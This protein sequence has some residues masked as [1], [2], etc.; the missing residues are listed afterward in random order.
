[1]RSVF[2]IALCLGFCFLVSCEEN[3]VAQQSKTGSRPFFP[4]DVV[5]K[6]TL[7]ENMD[8]LGKPNSISVDIERDSAIVHNYEKDNFQ[9]IVTYNTGT[10]MPLEVFVTTVNKFYPDDIN[11]YYNIAHVNTKDSSYTLVPYKSM[12]D[13]ELF[14]GLSIIPKSQVK[15]K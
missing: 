9:M 5:I 2:Y 7:Q 14:R 8:L 11:E 3:K 4:V 15:T 6:Q 12:N 1:M 10:K 13:L